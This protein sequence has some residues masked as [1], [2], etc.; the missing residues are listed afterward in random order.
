MSN[1]TVTFYRDKDYNDDS[2]EFDGARN[3]PDLSKEEYDGQSGLFGQMD[4]SISSLKTGSQA[5]LMVYSAH[6]YTQEFMKVCQSKSLDDLSTYFAFNNPA[7]NFDDTI[8]S[9]KLFDSPPNYFNIN[10][11]TLMGGTWL[12]VYGKKNFDGTGIN[13]FVF[14]AGD[15]DNISY[16][17]P[18]ANTTN[19][20]TTYFPVIA[21]L[22]TGPTAWVQLKDVYGN[23]W[24]F[25]P[26]SF[27]TDLGQYYVNSREF[28]TYSLASVNVSDSM[29]TDWD[30]SC[31]NAVPQM[32][33]NIQQ[34]ATANKLEGLV[35]S[36]V[37]DI[38][39][40]GDT[41]SFLMN[42]LWPTGF[43]TT[44]VW[45]D[46]QQYIYSVLGNLI[47]QADLKVLNNSLSSLSQDINDLYL[48]ITT[49]SP[50]IDTAGDFNNI[51]LILNQDEPYFIG[52]DKSG[53]YGQPEKQL[54]YQ[55]AFCSIE[56]VMRVEA[57]YNYT[58]ISG[59]DPVPDITTYR[60]DL[61]QKVSDYPSILQKQSVPNA[62]TWRKNQLVIKGSGNDQYVY[63]SYN[64]FIYGQNLDTDSA[65]SLLTTVQ[66]YVGSQYQQQLE[67][68]IL[69]SYLWGYLGTSNLDLTPPQKPI[70]IQKPYDIQVGSMTAVG[71]PFTLNFGLSSLKGLTMWGGNDCQYV[72]GI[73]FVYGDQQSPVYGTQQGKT[74]S[75]TFA[76]DE[77]IVGVYGRAGEYMDQ[78]FFRTMNSAFDQSRD[79]GLGGGGGDPF[80]QPAPSGVPAT[81]IGVSGYVYL[82]YLSQLTLHYTY[83]SYQPYTPP[84]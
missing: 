1:C 76:A 56:L 30:T 43:S 65:N 67:L 23:A 53:S 40:I 77:S 83:P 41:L 13:S 11:S 3:V 72:Y 66:D 47:D 84:A 29:P 19:N 82:G 17:N 60:T 69:P 64:G 7:Y 62:V 55:V 20:T 73:Q 54:S 37:G 32:V 48:D 12:K 9:F 59:E 80:Y 74:V 21:S 34:Y 35:S 45:D 70:P 5:W 26:N 18:T 16:L 36:L 33:L 58:A 6:N 2:R 71:T 52:G 24:C 49:G 39:A 51:I 79:L 8:V 4:D 38:P 50:G 75:A 14:G 44:V 68:F 78:L 10:D 63:D 42:A 81:L 27:I 61:D 28:D 15:I 25:G 31:T 22:A 57:A 46:L